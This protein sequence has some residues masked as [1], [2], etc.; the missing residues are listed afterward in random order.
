[1]LDA[2]CDRLLHSRNPAE[3]RSIFKGVS[4]HHAHPVLLDTDLL[5]E[6]MHIVGPPGTG[7]TTLGLENDVLQLIRRNDGP[8]VIFDCKGDPGLFHSVRLA[9]HGAGRVFKHFTNKPDRSTYVFNP[10]DPRLL[11]RLTLPDV[12]GLFTQSLNLHHGEDYGRG[13]FAVLARTLLRRGILETIPAFDGRPLSTEDGQRLLSL[14]PGPIRSFKDLLP[15]LQQLADDNEEFRAARHLTF[16]VES[17]T[18]FEQLNLAPNRNPDHPAIRHAIYMPEV[19]RQ[20]Q[21]VYFY[22]V[23]AMDV[24]SVAE[25]AKLALYCLLM[26]VIA[27]HDEHGVAPRVYTVWDEAQV[28]IAKN[29]ENVLAQARSHGLACILSHQSMSQL[30]PPGGVDLRELVMACT[31]VK[32]VFGARDPWLLKYI[33]ST[34]GTTKYFRQ[35]YNV[36]Q[37]DLLSGYVGAQYACAERDGACRINI[38]EYT[39]PRLTFQDVLDA[40]RHP[41]LSLMWIDRSSALS[42]FQGWF[43]VQTD[44]P[45]PKQLHDRNRREPWPAASEGTIEMSNIWPPESEGTVTPTTHPALAPTQPEIEYQRQAASHPQANSGEVTCSTNAERSPGIFF[46]PSIRPGELNIGGKSAVR[47][48]PTACWL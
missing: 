24:A 31:A 18:D 12:L 38:A 46:P 11:S 2:I 7:K 5:F 26:A 29:I 43:P 48:Q 17:L 21:V 13:W 30:N 15:I 10:W 33:S 28:M 22:L 35:S 36:S 34:S 8:V 40:G 32:Q 47:G 42:L 3:R 44:W 45:V 27:Y 4:Y 37:R 16:V 9:A 41:N 39:G 23:G 19:I 25:I 1:M 20:K 6:H 14:T